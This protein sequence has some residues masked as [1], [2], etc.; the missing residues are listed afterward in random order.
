FSLAS[1]DMCRDL[2]STTFLFEQFEHLNKLAKDQH[3]LPFRD[4]RIEQ[5]EKRFGF[6]GNGLV[7]DQPWM[8][9]DLT[10][11]GERGQDMN[12]AFVAAP[13]RNSLH[14]LLAA[15]AKFGQVQFALFF[16]QL[17]VTSLFNAI[18]Q[19]FGHV[20]LEAAQEQRSQFRREPLTG[21]ALSRFSI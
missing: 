11:P 10:Q 16:T 6:A 4:Q 8:A 2:V 1:K 21:N 12:L 19:V 17:A 5:F 18:G 13:L 9:A 20:L 3:L 7:A 15:A 14:D